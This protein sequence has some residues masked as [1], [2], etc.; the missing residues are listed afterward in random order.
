MTQLTIQIH[1][2]G[3]WH[4]AA[5]L[6]IKIPDRGIA[7]ACTLDYE[8]DYFIENGSGELAAGQ[9]VRDW[10]ALSVATPIDLEFRRFSNWPPFLLD[11]LPQG[12]ARRRLATELGFGN[13][14][15]P[16]VEYPLL[17]RGGG[18]P[19]GNLR[20]KE[21]W[22]AEQERV[23]TEVVRSGPCPGVT[24]DDIMTL[25]DAFRLVAERFALVASGSSGVQGEWPKILMTRSSTDDLWYPDP[26]IPDSEAAAHVI[27]KLSRGKYRED[28]LILESEAPYLEVARRFGLRVGAPLAY[29]PN[30]LLIP[31]FDRVAEGGHV[32][33]L[34]QESL[35]S[36]IGVAEFGYR[37]SHEAYLEVI[38]RETTKP[39]AEIVEYVLRDL[40][41]FAM[42]NPDNH[43]RNTALQKRA[44]GTVSL[45]PLFDFAPMRLDPSAITRSTRWACMGGPDVQPNWA[46]ICAVAVG[47]FM[48]ADEL[49]H[50]LLSRLDMLR[51]LPD[52]ARAAGVPDEAVM[53]ACRRH[54][55]MAERVAAMR[56]SAHGH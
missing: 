11:L 8:T 30:V 3:C 17:L 26:I 54:D 41:N 43:G 35:V 48:D 32:V 45:T 42:G 27:V 15:D 37:G 40:L 34:G 49:Q 51:A 10:R 18:C 50:E 16:A 20:I 55:D 31:R 53:V 23:A 52:I 44:D 25:N 5:V 29:S 9:A 47:D 2:G 1:H 6:D 56:M 21:A 46:A 14:D 39:K 38:K 7:S 36:A 19:I 22:K 12:H 4:D 33:R 24:T 28:M 13:A